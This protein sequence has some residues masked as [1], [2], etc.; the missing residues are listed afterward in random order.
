MSLRTIN[1]IVSVEDITPKTE[2]FAGIVGE[3]NVTDLVFT[4]D[5]Q[6]QQK[7]E[8]LEGETV[9]RVEASNGEGQYYSSTL[10]TFDAVSGTVRFSV[11]GDLTTVGGAVSINLVISKIL[12]ENEEKTLYSYPARISFKNSAGD[13]VPQE[14]KS[15][16]SG[17]LKKIEDKVL[18]VETSAKNTEASEANAKI[19]ETNAKVSETNAEEAN[20]QCQQ[21]L[22]EVEGLLEKNDLLSGTNTLKKEVIAD[23]ICCDD[24]SLGSHDIEFTLEHKNLCPELLVGHFSDA[25]F[26]LTDTISTTKRCIKLENTEYSFY[27][28]S[29]NVPLKV[30]NY[31]YHK[32]LYEV[33]ATTP[34]YFD[35]VDGVIGYNLERA[36]GKA[37]TG[38]EEVKFQKRDY[39]NV[40]VTRYGKNLFKRSE[41]LSDYSSMGGE[42]PNFLTISENGL[43]ATS[44]SDGTRFIISESP[45]KISNGITLTYSCDTS[46]PCKF[47]ALVKLYDKNGNLLTSGINDGGWEYNSNYPAFCY[48]GGTLQ[49]N[50]ALTFTI[51]N[52][53]VSYMKVG[54]AFYIESDVAEEKEM[55]FSNLQLE[56][57]DKKTEYEAFVEPIEYTTEFDGTY[58]GMEDNVVK[59]VTSLYPS[60]TFINNG[61]CSMKIN[62]N[63][64]L[65]KVINKIEEKLYDSL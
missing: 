16:L 49:N 57:G 54:L 8:T 25:N 30:V 22:T 53:N 65:I 13:K 60:M 51:N 52:E 1:Y 6:L 31:I 44:S 59:N 39:S 33:G 29:S 42:V 64:D 40:T 41:N 28:L 48:I 34:L 62:Y 55:T 17:T 37:W 5:S 56:I 3:N 15:A 12:N 4:L 18:A 23:A 43:T 24:V 2:Q 27:K 50:H 11:P 36:D 58:N 7:L 61:G 46:V 47:L 26:T 35:E 21:I 20:K 63:R 14:F 45:I 9:F 32:N 38:E 19:S 10:L